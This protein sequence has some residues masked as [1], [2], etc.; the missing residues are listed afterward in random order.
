LA[1]P[2]PQ[3]MKR[4]LLLTGLLIVSIS[5]AQWIK[6]PCPSPQLNAVTASNSVVYAGAP[7]GGVTF[8]YDGGTT[9]ANKYPNGFTFPYIWN[10]M[11]DGP[12]LLAATQSGFY[13]SVDSAKYF[14][15]K[16]TGLGNDTV[17]FCLFRNG[18][19][20]FAGTTG[21]V[22]KSTNNGSSWT[23]SNNGITSGDVKAIIKSGATLL[24]GTGGGGVFA[25]ID[26]GANWSLS[27]SGLTGSNISALIISGS[28]VF[29]GT[30]GNGVFRSTD[31][32]AT[33]TAA[34]TGL[35]NQNTTAMISGGSNI[36]A[37]S[38]AG[39]FMSSNNGASWTA[40]NTGLTNT[41]VMSMAITGN[42]MYLAVNMSGVWKRPLSEMTGPVT[43]TGEAS[44]V[45][46]KIYPNPA[47]G[48]VTISGAPAGSEIRLCDLQGRE[49]AK[50]HSSGR[51]I[52]FNTEDLASGSY[53]IV[54]ENNHHEISRTK[55]LV[56][57]N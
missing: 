3:K 57:G 30:F 24:A 35:I 38:M 48:D 50:F 32:G 44:T 26:N 10:L 12:E 16:N 23:L 14:A 39:V 51:V 19:T 53:F 18:T 21:G 17:V 40:V 7:G 52:K 41:A 47:A 4:P 22:Y 49:I 31:N 55:L 2:K 29:A 36:F 8:S 56:N 9:W 54:V 37:A 5:H 33:W 34:S 11:I 25:S 45:P 13:A 1:T 46:V 15:Q 20:L 27:S 6:T 28:N 42:N 43:T